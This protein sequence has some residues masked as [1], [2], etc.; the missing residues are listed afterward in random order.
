MD[1]IEF[2]NSV[3]AS[4]EV[5]LPKSDAP[6]LNAALAHFGDVRGKRLLDLG[7]GRG[8]ISV[9]FASKGA[10]VVSIDTSPTAIDKLKAFCRK[11]AIDNIEPRQLSAMDIQDIGPFD[12]IVGS[13][14]LHHIEPFAD[15]AQVLS[16]ALAPSGKAFFY[17]NNAYSD[18]LIWFRAHVV[19]KLWIPKTSDN[20]EFPLMPS[21]IAALRKHF[22]VRIEYPELLFFRLISMCILR[23]RL[24]GPFRRL[25]QYF[26]RFE[27]MRK[28]S[29]RQYVMLT[30][31][32]R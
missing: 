11:H 6:V 31:L 21:E 17:E 9:F 5:Q 32:P 7:C 24:P 28:Y 26:Y 15:F 12:C 10:N 25:D 19:G 20:E 30:G 27:G 8:E 18:L 13:M 23:G 1:S 22:D 29:Y 4:G 2:W 3:Y 16:R 14:I